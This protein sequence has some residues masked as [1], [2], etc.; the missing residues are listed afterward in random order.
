MRDSQKVQGEVI[1]GGEEERS[2]VGGR[3]TED[4]GQN[5]VGALATHHKSEACLAWPERSDGNTEGEEE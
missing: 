4:G 2:E 3:K 5:A 1:G